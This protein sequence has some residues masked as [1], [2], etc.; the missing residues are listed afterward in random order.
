MPSDFRLAIAPRRAAGKHRGHRRQRNRIARVDR[1]ETRR[2]TGLPVNRRRGG[3]RLVGITSL[4]VAIAR[5]LVDAPRSPGRP[6]CLS[7]ADRGGYPLVRALLSTR[8]AGWPCH[9]NLTLRRSALKSRRCGGGSLDESGVPWCPTVSKTQR[10]R[11]RYG[12]KLKSR[13]ASTGGGTSAATRTWTRRNQRRG[14]RRPS[15]ARARLSRREKVRA[16]KA[17]QLRL[18]YVCRQ[19]SGESL[20]FAAVG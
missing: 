8:T 17:E 6:H 19:V 2:R 9:R 18:A 3:L 10:R 14:V 15:L 20:A 13:R 16:A 12:L 4:R 11:S 1:P 5:S 7:R